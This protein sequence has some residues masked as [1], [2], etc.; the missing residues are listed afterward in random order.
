[1]THHQ[2]RN[3]IKNQKNQV[4]YLTP[5]RKVSRPLCDY[6]NVCDR[7]RWGFR[8]DLN[9]GTQPGIM[10][11]VDRL[12]QIYYYPKPHLNPLGICGANNASNDQSTPVVV[13]RTFLLNCKLSRDTIFSMM[14]MNRKHSPCITYNGSAHT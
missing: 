8:P 14:R 13:V 6:I 5:A 9:L 12:F 10:L 2:F 3:I 7:I 1:M 11:P 4:V